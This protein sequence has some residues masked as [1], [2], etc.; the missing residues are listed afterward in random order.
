M[1]SALAF[2]EVPW[3]L[4]GIV[5]GLGL[6]VGRF[7][8]GWVCPTGFVQDLLFKIPSPKIELPRWMRLIKYGVLGISVVGVSYFL[9]REHI[10]SFCKWCPTATASDGIPDVLQH[11]STSAGW[12]VSRWAILTAVIVFA[13]LN[14][15]SFCKVLC[16]VGALV[17]VPGRFSWLAIRLNAAKCM[18]CRQCDKQCPMDVK[19]EACKDS[20][21]RIN[22][23]P[24]CVN[25]LTCE[26][27]CTKQAIDNNSRILKR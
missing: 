8:C 18:R 25:C 11:G 4:L 1:A 16:P 17:S 5:V 26:A 21:H 14:H 10:L 22:R 24:E 6:L 23:D 15:R 12:N 7:F 2:H 13:V 19:V 9:G 27:V 3:L 20:G